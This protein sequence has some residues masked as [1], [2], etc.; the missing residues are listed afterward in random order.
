MDEYLLCSQ[1]VLEKII[2]LEAVCGRDVGRGIQLLVQA[3]KGGL[4]GAALS[5]AEHPSPHVAIITG[6]FIPDG[7]P[8]APETDGITGCAMLAAALIQV[9]IPVRIVTDSLCCHAVEIALEAAGVPSDVPFDVIHVDNTQ[10]NQQSVFALL[11]LWETS[12]IPVSHVI[13]IERAGPGYDGIVRNMR[14]QDI[15]DYTAPM[16]L[17]LSSPKIIS[18]GIGDGGNELGMGKIP[19]DIV[20]QSVRYGEKI[21]CAVSCDYLIVCGVSNWGVTGLLAAL[22]LL[23]PDWKAAISEGLNPETELHILERTVIEG[24][25]VDGITGLQSL[26]VDNLFW[27]VYAEVL[28]IASQLIL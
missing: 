12:A 1:D 3:A 9:N 15:T 11:N 10:Q 14:G 27:E 18:I 8:P 7:N 26:T 13:S 6:F 19:R 5:I 20:S 4:L 22:C 16:H 23:R 21:A 25:A 2:Q 24:P 17:L 28:Q